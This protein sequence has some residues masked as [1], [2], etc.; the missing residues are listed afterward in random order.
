MV[1]PAPPLIAILVTIPSD[2]LREPAFP[3]RQAAGASP[4]NLGLK[5]LP[6]LVQDESKESPPCCCCLRGQ[7]PRALRHFCFMNDLWALIV[8]HWAKKPFHS[9]TRGNFAAEGTEEEIG[10]GITK[11]ENSNLV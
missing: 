3:L 4:R 1:S 6:D 7:V 11:H 5:L 9:T 2:R 8:S 10:E